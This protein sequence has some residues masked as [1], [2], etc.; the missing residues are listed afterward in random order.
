MF[1]TRMLGV[2][3][4]PLL[5]PQLV[6]EKFWVKTIWGEKKPNWTLRMAWNIQKCKESGS[7]KFL[8]VKKTFCFWKQ[9]LFKIGRAAQKSHFRWGGRW[10]RQTTNQTDDITEWNVESL[11]AAAK[12]VTCGDKLKAGDGRIDPHSPCQSPVKCSQNLMPPSPLAS[13][14]CCLSIKNEYGFKYHATSQT[15]IPNYLTRKKIICFSFA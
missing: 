2:L 1:G 3:R 8:K 13:T 15:P 6:E 11:L 7:G 12:K 14:P 9:K 10:N 4:C 5:H